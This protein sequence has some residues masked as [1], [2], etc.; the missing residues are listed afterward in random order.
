MPIGVYPRTPRPLM[1][2]PTCGKDFLGWAWK[3]KADLTQYCGRACLY[4]RL[5]TKVDRVCET[6][7]R[8]FKANPSSVAKGFARFCDQACTT[9]PPDERFWEKVDR[10]GPTPI[11]RPELGPC[12]VWTSAITHGYGVFQDISPRRVIL[13]HRRAWQMATGEK[14]TSAIAILH[15][16]D[17]PLCVR[18][19]TEDTYTVDGVEYPQRGHLVRGTRAVNMADKMAKG[20]YKAGRR[21][22]G[23]QHYKA[24]L[25]EDDVRSIISMIDNGVSRAAVARLYKMSPTTIGY[26]YDRRIWKHV[27]VSHANS[28]SHLNT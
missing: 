16:C 28:T 24:K 12:W 13:A 23:E 7:G 21:P 15:A 5:A 22:M 18:N 6:C 8:V 17:T 14:L 26:I 10:N 9:R 27:D 25:T 1:A 2:C 4:R 11:H 20:R 19:D 3:V